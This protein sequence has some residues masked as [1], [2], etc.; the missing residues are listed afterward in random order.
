MINTNT[1]KACSII[2]L[3]IGGVC[4]GKFSYILGKCAGYLDILDLMDEECH[5]LKKKFIKDFINKHLIDK[6]LYK[7]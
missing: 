7:C 3:T 5:G 1:K 6:V 4:I 2:L